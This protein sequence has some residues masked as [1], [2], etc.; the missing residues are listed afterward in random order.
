MKFDPLQPRHRL[1]VSENRLM[2]GTFETKREEL[3]D[4][5]KSHR[6]MTRSFIN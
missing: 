3:T 6:P 1:R 2:R 4:D 5:R